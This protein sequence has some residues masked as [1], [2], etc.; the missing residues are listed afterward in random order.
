MVLKFYTKILLYNI[1]KQPHKHFDTIAKYIS[2]D[3][4]V[5]VHDSF[6]QQTELRGI[7]VRFLISLGFLLDPVLPS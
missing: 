1:I 4:F 2:D 6:S 5:S 3:M 7:A